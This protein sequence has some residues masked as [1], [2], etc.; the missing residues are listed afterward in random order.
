[1]TKDF[2][3]ALDLLEKEKKISKEYLLKKIKDA[4]A[5]AYKKETKL[6]NISVSI[7]EEKEIIKCLGEKNTHQIEEICKNANDSIHFV[8]N[9][10]EGLESSLAEIEKKLAAVF[11]TFNNFFACI[12]YFFFA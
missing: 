12:K 1:M 10:A 9:L 7:D 2:F 3:V 6:S 4:L 11:I 5:I 8:Q